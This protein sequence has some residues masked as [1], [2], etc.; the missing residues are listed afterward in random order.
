MTAS[1]IGELLDDLQRSYDGDPWHGSSLTVLLDGVTASV[2]IATPIASVHSIWALVLHLTAWTDEVRLRLEGKA[3]DAPP[4]GDWPAVPT[5]PTPEAW[6][7]AQDALRD[8]QRALEAAV[9][10][11]PHTMLDAIVGGERDPALGAG[12]TYAATI[13]GLV[14]HHAYHGGQIAILRKALER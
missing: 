5:H 2:A 4:Q 12:L 14:Q 11:L 8:A 1:R 10:A 13:R 9:A 7:A 3:P 6:R